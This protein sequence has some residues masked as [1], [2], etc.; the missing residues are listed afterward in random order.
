MNDVLIIA[1]SDPTGS[2]GVQAD[3][4]TMINFGIKPA[5]IITALT[6]QDDK[7]VYGCFVVPA[8]HVSAVFNIIK[9]K[10]PKWIKIGMLGNESIVDVI[11]SVIKKIP[12]RKIILDPVY[13]STSG[14]HLNNSRGWEKMKTDLFPECYLITPNI[15]EAQLLAGIKISKEEDIF[16]AVHKIREMGPENVLIKG[17][18]LSGDPVDTLYDGKKMYHF[19]GKRVYNNVMRGTGCRFAS[20][21]TALLAKGIS[22]Q[23]AVKEAKDY[24]FSYYSKMK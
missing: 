22:L 2:A 8:E 4:E 24:I 9:K 11:V 3:L 13:A 23:E 5:H 10:P 7:R 16:K 18:H 20:A 17:G 21:I 14:Y 19:S 6:V 15:A 1:G 12:G